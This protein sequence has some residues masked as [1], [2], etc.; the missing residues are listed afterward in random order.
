MISIFS[1]LSADNWG[2]GDDDGLTVDEIEDISNV[3]LS[4]QTDQP[5]EHLLQ[6][7]D[8]NRTFVLSETELTQQNSVSMDLD[9]SMNDTNQNICQPVEG[10]TANIR[11][12]I[13]MALDNL[14]QTEG[15]E[16]LGLVERDRIVV[17]VEKL[18]ELKGS[19]CKENLN[20]GHI[21]NEPLK[22][23]SDVQGTVLKLRWSCGNGHLGV[24]VSSE[25]VCQS[26]NSNVY[27]NDL[28]VTACVLLSGNS[29]VKFADLCSFLNLAVPNKSSFCRNQR[30]YFTPVILSMWNEMRCTIIDV[31]GEFNEVV[32]GG[33]GRND[34][35]G[36]SAR[37]CVYVMM[38]IISSVIVDM[39]VLDK[40][41][42]GGVSGNMEREGMTRIL[43]RLKGL[44]DLAEIATDASSSII[45]RI[46]ELKGRYPSCHMSE[47]ILICL[48]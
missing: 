8:I 37:F 43:L 46:K 5:L 11:G 48:Q 34:S 28:V 15:I 16:E 38:D 24:W 25:V 4:E 13:A 26:R 32:L 23:Q 27:L 40:R 45:K 39:E 2:D 14:F 30:L 10:N 6:D 41:E 7:M 35:P 17:S 33:D 22:F 44:L 12:K 31:L 18:K 9:C 29:Y 19:L 20:T 21:C 3:C 36:F 47:R 1:E 42:T